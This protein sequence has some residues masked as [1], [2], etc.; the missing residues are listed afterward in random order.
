LSVSSRLDSV[1]FQQV[2]LELNAVTGAVGSKRYAFR[3]LERMKQIRLQPEP[4]R[5]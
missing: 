4:V 3:D 1:V 5:L 2:P